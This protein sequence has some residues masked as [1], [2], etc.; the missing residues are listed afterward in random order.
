[1]SYEDY[2][3]RRLRSNKTREE[4]RLERDIAIGAG[5]TAVICVVLAYMALKATFGV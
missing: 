1:M 5:V 3:L 4:K 2:I